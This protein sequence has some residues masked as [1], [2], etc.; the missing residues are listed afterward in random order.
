MVA[1]IGAYIISFPHLL[2]D[3]GLDL[4]LAVDFNNYT[5]HWPLHLQRDNTEL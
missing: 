2:V 4:L 3:F 5:Q 1:I